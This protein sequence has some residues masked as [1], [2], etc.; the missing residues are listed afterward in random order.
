[1]EENGSTPSDRLESMLWRQIAERDPSSPALLVRA[2]DLLE[3]GL[4][5][6]AMETIKARSSGPS[7]LDRTLYY[8]D[9]RFVRG[10]PD[11]GRPAVT[12]PNRTIAE[13]DRRPVGNAGRSPA[14]PSIRL[15]LATG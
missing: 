5:V 4:A 13:T 1:M 7:P 12:D 9:G 15:F 10:R 6:E 11:R 2:Q 3:A 8:H 14:R